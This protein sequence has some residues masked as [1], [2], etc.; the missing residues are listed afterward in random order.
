MAY[1][2]GE[3]PM[4][5]T[6]QWSE[7]LLEKLQAHFGDHLVFAGI[8]REAAHEAKPAMKAISTSSPYSI[9]LTQA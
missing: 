5:D 9:C 6:E 3:N 7:T 4:I 2:K 1:K 8:H